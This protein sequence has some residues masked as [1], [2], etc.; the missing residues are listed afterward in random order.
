MK[1]ITVLSGKGGVGKS[2]I[3]SSLALAL[4]N[5]QKEI[6]CADCD[7]EASNLSLV[8]GGKKNKIQESFDITTNQVAQIDLDKCSFCKKCY[9]SC[10]FNAISWS[11]GKPRVDEFVCEGCNV[12]GL[13]CPEKAITMKEIKNAKIRLEKSPYGFKIVTGDLGI[14]QSGSGKVVAE[15]KKFAEK[16]SDDSDFMLVDSSAGVGCPVIASITGSHYVVAVTEPSP[17]GFSDLKRA[18]ELVD[19]FKID[20]GLIINKFDLNESYMNKILG[21]A[22]KHRIPILGKIPYDAGIVTSLV[23]LRP[24]Y[25]DHENYKNLFDDVVL[26]IFYDMGLE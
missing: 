9:D 2:T 10:Y 18:I 22:K 26:K 15:V 19:H 3:T 14:G 6:I 5:K 25:D 13:V 12:C 7:V 4:K 1:K 17:S 16:N 8:L 11:G 21:F 20:F 24:I 23:N